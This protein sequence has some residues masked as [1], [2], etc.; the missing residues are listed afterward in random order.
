MQF[1]KIFLITVCS[2]PALCAPIGEIAKRNPIL[3]V[4]LSAGKLAKVHVDENIKADVADGTVKV[5]V[6]PNPVECVENILNGFS[7]E[8]PSSDV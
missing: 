3:T 1:S 4:D 8:P 6:T 5:D 7:C 2:I